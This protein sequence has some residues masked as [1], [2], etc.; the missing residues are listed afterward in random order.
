M[1]RVSVLLLRVGRTMHGRHVWIV[2][3]LTMVV[4]CR[5]M[6]R[7]MMRMRWIR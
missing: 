7:M 3:T 6:I 2:A 1:V 4:L 5:V